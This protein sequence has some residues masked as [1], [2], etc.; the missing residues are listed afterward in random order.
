MRIPT[1]FLAFFSF[2]ISF[3]QEYA[4]SNISEEL[5]KNADAVVRLDQMNVLVK[6]RDEM[7]VTSKRIVTVLNESGD[8]FVHAWG[9]YDKSTRITE[10]EAKIYNAQGKEIKK[11]KRKDF[12]DQSAV[13]GGT[14]YSD[15]RVLFMRYTPTDYPYTVEF[16]RS[17]N[18]INT[19]FVPPWFFVDGYRVSTEKSL[20]TFQIDCGI[21]F[22]HKEL[23]LD[24]YGI[25]FVDQGNRV[26]YSGS[27]I[28]AIKRE[29]YSPSLREFTPRIQIALNQF[30]LEGVDGSGENWEDLGRWIY[31]ELLIGQGAL[32][33]QTIQKAKDLVGDTTDPLE[34]VHKIYD[35][36]QSNTR[37]ISVQLGIGGWMPISASEVDRVK[38]GDC[39]GLTNYMMALLKAVGVESYYTVVY[40]GRQKR[41][42]D[43]GFTLMQGNH[44]FLNVPIGDDEVWLECTSQVTPVNHLGTFTDNRNVLKVTPAGGEL[45]RTKAY[46]DEDNYQLTK[47]EYFAKADG[48]IEGKVEILSTGT[49]YNQKFRNLQKTELEREKFYKDYWGYINNLSLGKIDFTNDKRTIEFKENVELSADAY[50]SSVDG[51]LMFA[52]NIGNRNL[53]VPERIRS[54]KRDLLISRGYLDEDEFLIHLPEGYEPESLLGTTKLDTKFGLYEIE[55][56]E[57]QTGIL[58]YKR[59]LLIKSGRYS[60]EDYKAFRDFRK[61]IARHDNSRIILTK[62]K[63]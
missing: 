59:K 30:H 3:S 57:K 25:E 35:F 31:N 6:E 56:S 47:A 18:T 34:K 63:P 40:A 45:V 38:Y 17:Y 54:R 61:Q 15:S 51:K 12:Q 4:V 53:H 5:L 19:A 11:I 27:N 14:L 23:N 24:D 49:Q 1:L 33:A 41:D 43:E 42:F 62:T 7:L 10:I 22:R 44:A 20:Y 28:N 55:L 21:A 9:F 50:L 52:P 2:F 46:S 8:D 48:Q 39:K 13:S 58:L 36:V 60:K 29:A 32:D 37:Y 26:S 16:T